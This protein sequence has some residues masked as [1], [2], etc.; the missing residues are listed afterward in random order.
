MG[1]SVPSTRI[2]AAVTNAKRV[3]PIRKHMETDH[4]DIRNL[5]EFQ[6]RSIVIK[7]GAAASVISNPSTAYMSRNPT[8]YNTLKE[9]AIS[10]SGFTSS[11][12]GQGCGVEFHRDTLFSKIPYIASIW[13]R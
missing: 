9:I 1:R 5:S 11:N 6:I 2:K 13:P 7:T 3:I 10:V 8:E 12:D 4:M